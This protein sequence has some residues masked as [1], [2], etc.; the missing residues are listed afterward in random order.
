MKRLNLGLLKVNGI[1][2]EAVKCVD[3][4]RNINGES[5]LLGHYQHLETKARGA[6]GI[7]YP[8]SPSCKLWILKIDLLIKL[9]LAQS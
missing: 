6:N 5:N 4:K 3:I 1:F 7:R 8:S 2:S 9:L